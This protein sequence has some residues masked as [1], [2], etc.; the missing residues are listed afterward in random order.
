[1]S[2]SDRAQVC[3]NLLSLFLNSKSKFKSSEEEKQTNKSNLLKCVMADERAWPSL[4]KWHTQLPK[5][6][7]DVSLENVSSWK[8]PVNEYTHL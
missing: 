1:M 4:R 6:P 7:K 8:R 5:T 3:H 2:L